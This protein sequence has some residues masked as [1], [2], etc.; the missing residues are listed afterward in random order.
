[1]NRIQAV[2]RTLLQSINL[3][4][5]SA[6]ALSLALLS[7]ATRAYAIDLT[8]TNAN[9]T[10]STAQNWDPALAPAAGDVTIFTNG[11]SY[12][13]SFSAD[14]PSLQS[15]IF[16]G[17]AGIVTLNLGTSN[18][19]VTNSFRV[20]RYDSSA[21]V[22]MSSGTLSV[23]DPVN[24]TASLRVG[25]AGTNIVS[26]AGKFTIA[27]GTVVID[28]AVVGGNSNSVGTLVISGSGQL[29]PGASGSTITL[30]AGN[31]TNFTGASFGNQLIVTN[32][33]ILYVDGTLTA[34]NS[35][36][37]SNTFVLFS[38]PTTVGSFTT[39]LKIQ[40]NSG[41]MIVSNGAKLFTQGSFLFGGSSSWNTGVVV[42]AGSA[43]I[44]AG[45]VQIGRGSDG[46]TNN[47]FTIANGGFISCGGTFAWGNNAENI[48][49]G[50]NF[51]GAGAMST[52]LMTVVRSASNFTNHFGNFITVTNAFVSS[53]YLN[54]QGPSEKISILSKG[55]YML[56]NSF[57]LTSAG[58]GTNCVSFN[59]VDSTM[60]IDGGTLT[61]LRTVDN[62]GGFSFAGTGIPGNSG[63]IGNTL[64]VTNGGRL[65]TSGGTIG[66]GSSFNTGIVVG[67]G[68]VW[69]N[70]SG[71]AVDPNLTNVLIVG[72]G[73]GGSNSCLIIY[74]GATL[75]NNGTL[76]I[77]NVVSA[78]VSSVRIGGVGLP[79][80]VVN[81][82]SL[83]IGASSNAFD[84]ALT[85]TNA[86]L[87]TS[88]INVG[89]S[90]ATNNLLD[91]R[92]G[93]TINVGF[94]RVRPTNT[95]VFNAGTFSA[96]GLTFDTSANSGNPFLVGDGTSSATYS[97]ANG[98]TGFHD[99]NTG[100][101]VI[102]NNATLSGSGT[103]VGNVTVLGTFDPGLGVAVGTI[104]A[105]NNL[106]FGSSAS[107]NYLLGTSQDSVTVNG[108]LAL[109][110]TVNVT[111]N[112]GFTATTY[113]LFTHTNTVTGTLAVGTLP[114]GYSATVSTNILPLVQLIVTATGGG[115]DP[116]ATWQQQYFGS[117]SCGTCGGTN[118]FD[119]DGMNNTN[120]FLAGFNPA[121]NAA[122][123][124]V[125]S[126]VRT[127]TT[128][129][130]VTYLGANGN[131]TTVPPMASRTNVLE[132]SLGGVG[133][134]TGNNYS[135]NFT[136]AQTNILSGGTGLG[137][138]S[139]FIDTNGA[140]GL[141]RYYRVRVLVP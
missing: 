114:P 31:A 103:L 56:S 17:Q 23:L 64:I 53:R 74:D 60:L 78:S 122:Y 88:I 19:T 81:A 130:K 57:A 50:I 66:A 43:I 14:T 91:L 86:T 24:A 37:S 116:F 133:G 69:S 79:S 83:N 21:E 39:A 123:L 45:S 46:A 139:S 125:I 109:G 119:G 42:G 76:S 140:A 95:V 118:D 16:S 38:G 137:G 65:L 93:G 59:G 54:P 128:D 4:G 124:H 129:I 127:N 8:W 97:M 138:V 58:Q 121:N 98:G 33:G 35:P 9:G 113:T 6:L 77:A 126:V 52:G 141:T 13:V 107:L 136:S 22:F 110:G 30:G 85:V 117:T 120:E 101:L 72:T 84:N 12:T 49:N 112:A 47:V 34:G 11:T 48:T 106:T 67:V 102:T 134:S 94:M 70:F 132:I 115:A 55:T 36:A 73:S 99:F 104:Y 75:Y 7:G 100:G 51:G 20:G 26:A 28:S 1:M 29:L 44:A 61:D 15:C 80:T 5:I 10:F 27:G 96:G 63:V 108:N 82:G 3:R 90:G 111:S 87:T 89:N 18:L 62:G 71:Q 68:S 41:L 92:K 135:N 32:G 131:S 40:G 25:D 2:R 105:S